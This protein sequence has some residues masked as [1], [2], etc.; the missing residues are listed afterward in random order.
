MSRRPLR[1]GMRWTASEEQRLKKLARQNTPTRL[2]GLKLQRTEISIRSKAHRL[3]LSLKPAN[4]SP[5][6]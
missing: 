2:I 5:Y 6:G 4:R 1:D 3:D